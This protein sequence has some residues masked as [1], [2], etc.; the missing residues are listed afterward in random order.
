MMRQTDFRWIP[1]NYTTSLAI[2]A[3][4]A[5]HTQSATPQAYAL[6]DHLEPL[7]EGA[8]FRSLSLRNLNLR[9]LNLRNQLCP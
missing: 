8:A 5:L 9:N 2:H 7:V 4:V 3:T 1:L 6:V